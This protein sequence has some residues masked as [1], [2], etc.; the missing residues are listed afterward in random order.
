[1]RSKFTERLSKQVSIDFDGFW[2]QKKDFI[3]LS[4][5]LIKYIDMLADV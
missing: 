4:K 5:P 2:R 3:F 1:M